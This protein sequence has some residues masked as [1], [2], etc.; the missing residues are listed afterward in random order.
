V[1]DIY[2]IRDPDYRGV[3]F[4]PKERLVEIV[5]AAVEAGLQFTAHTVG[6]GAV[7]T[8]LEAYE[9]V[10]RTTPV[11]KT[12]PC[13]SHSNFMSREAVNKLPAL[14][15]SVDIQPAWLHLD[16]RT[17]AQ[18]FGYERLRW[19]QP[20][21]SIFETGGLAGGGSD[22][23]QKIGSMRAL[24]PYNPFLGMATAITRKAKWYD[25]ALHP[26]EA[27]TREQA[28][29]FYTINNAWLMFCDDRLGSLEPGKL[30]DF[31]VLDTD[32]LT[33]PPDAIGR[34]EVRKTYVDGKLVFSHE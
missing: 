12:R 5:R 7:Q 29:R 27:L 21:R 8:L 9:E 24:N 16:T 2:A 18:H 15:V 4:I 13:I 31:I 25:G 32:L 23:M 14:G 6:D 22:H 34:A 19:F 30:A 17:L 10:N 3:L 1:S 26:E 33:C 11:R 20:L 28:V